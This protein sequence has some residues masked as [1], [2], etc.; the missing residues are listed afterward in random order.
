VSLSGRVTIWHAVVTMIQDRPWIGHGFGSFWQTQ[1]LLNGLGARTHLSE[2]EKWIDDA[3]VINQAHNGYLDLLLSVGII[4][5]VLV[6]GAHFVA[7][8]KLRKLIRRPDVKSSDRYAFMAV[9]SSILTILLNNFLES[10]LFYSPF[11]SV[12]AMMLMF[13]VYA[14]AWHAME[15]R[16][17]VRM[18][19]VPYADP[20]IVE[21]S[22]T[23]VPVY[24]AVGRSRRR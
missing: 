19:P 12:G 14:N 21:A 3:R 20:P 7:L 13:L 22:T 4:G 2:M 11:Y 24:A 6:V 8:N 16:T 10:T 18:T 9:H 15:R 1:D 5:L 17:V 23:P